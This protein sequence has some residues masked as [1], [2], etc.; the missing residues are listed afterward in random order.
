MS[1]TTVC[2]PMWGFYL[3]TSGWALIPA[4]EFCQMDVAKGWG[5]KEVE[6]T[7]RQ[8]LDM[9]VH[10]ALAE[11]RWRGR[12]CCDERGEDEVV[13]R[14]EKIKSE[15]RELEK[16]TCGE[17][18]PRREREGWAA[19][20]G[21]WAFVPK[22]SSLVMRPDVSPGEGWLRRGKSKAIWDEIVRELWE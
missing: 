8:W 22:V 17:D 1:S 21:I 18:K 3:G 10:G 15:M 19:G 7:G 5:R 16:S 12:A 20:V 14:G 6:D 9:I 13:M 2:Y 11:Q 4:L